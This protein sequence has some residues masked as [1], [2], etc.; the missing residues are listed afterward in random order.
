MP[1]GSDERYRVVRSNAFQKAWDDGVA[2]GWLDPAEHKLALDFYA[3]VILP[4]A[5]FT[6]GEPVPDAAAN[7]LSFRFPRSLRSLTFIE[8]FYSIVEDDRMVILEDIHLL[9]G[10]DYEL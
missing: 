2:A 9:P 1:L 8:I 4:Q 7:V 6:A 5:P 3:N 10:A